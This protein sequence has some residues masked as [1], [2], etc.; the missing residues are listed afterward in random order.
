M[1]AP[2]SL[3]PLMLVLCARSRGPFGLLPDSTWTLKSP[4][5]TIVVLAL[6]DANTVEM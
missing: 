4:A 6:T 1:H 3:S 5:M 2:N